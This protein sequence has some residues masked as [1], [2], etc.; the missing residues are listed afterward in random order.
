MGT[1]RDPTVKTRL[2]EDD[3]HL[4]ALLAWAVQGCLQWQKEGLNPPPEVVDATEDYREDSQ[5]LTPFLEDR[6]VVG[7]EYSTAFQP[8]WVDYQE[9]GSECHIESTDF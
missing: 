3:E 4:R 2:K 9:L 5:P 8:L 1:D 6:C 7:R